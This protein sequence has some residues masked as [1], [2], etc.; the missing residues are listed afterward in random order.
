MVF[1]EKKGSCYSKGYES[2]G[3]AGALLM[4]L[5]LQG[6]ITL[7]ENSIEIVDSNSTG[8]ELLDKI[9][10]EIKN[11]ENKRSLMKWIDKISQKY[12]YSFF[13]LMEHQGILKSEINPDLTIKH[14]YL[15]NPEN[16][17]QLLEE[18]HNVV[19]NKKPPS[20]NIIC[21]LAL[22]EESKLIKIY[23]PRD[24]RKKTR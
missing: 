1:D 6:K 5:T 22:L 16:K 24:L 12:S 3:F 18:I 14:H 19:N 2:L 17:S 15:Q 21:L 7:A 23:M 13:D 8:D 10:E 20:I 9:L 4:D 11:S